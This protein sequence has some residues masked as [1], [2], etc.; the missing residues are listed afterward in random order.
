MT[1]QVTDNRMGAPV[2]PDEGQEVYDLAIIGAGPA[3]LT[4]ALYAARAGLSTALFERLSPG[5]QCAQTEHLENYPGYTRST[6][7]FELSMDMYDQAL[8]FGAKAIMEDVTSVDFSAEPNKLVTPFNTYFARTVIVATGAVASQLGLPREDELRGRGVSY[9][10]TCDGAFFR[11]K[12]VAVVGGGDTA[13]SDA[14]YLSK[15]ASKVYLIHRRDSFRASRFLVERVQARENIRC[16]M[17]TVVEEVLGEE[18]VQ[19]LRLRNVSNGNTGTLEVNGLF[20]AVGI[21][22]NSE[23]VR[24]LVTLD[25]SGFVVAGEDC[26]TSM[27]GVFAAGDLR[28]KPLRQIVC[29]V[30]DGAVAVESALEYLE[31][32]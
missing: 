11:N 22:P 10:A 21:Q 8:S 25:E 13:A 20:V 1:E 12:T 15:L 9:C 29:A 14:L 23:L 30:S 3:G 5:G 6:S 19:G 28:T 26:K 17:S 18:R 7:G 2:G 16:I 32:R 4:A 24:G 31:S 27:P